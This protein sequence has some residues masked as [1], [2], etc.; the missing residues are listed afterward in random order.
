MWFKL[1]S[2]IL[3]VILIRSAFTK[4]FDNSNDSSLNELLPQQKL[5]HYVGRN[6]L[7]LAE[8]YAIKYADI[9]RAILKDKTLLS[10]HTPEVENF[11]NKLIKF[12]ENYENQKSLSQNMNIMEIFANTTEYY[13]KLPEENH[14]ME[15][16]FILKLLNKYNYKEIEKD[17][18]KDFEPFIEN[19]EK[20][21]EEYEGNWDRTLMDW[22]EKFKTLKE[23]EHKLEAFSEFMELV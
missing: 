22:Y 11:K 8:E 21:F 16:R 4:S 10:E 5:L 14:T 19:F 6:F 17:I 20:L 18:A 3:F 9:S 2:I 13:Y 12:L 15:T 23:F 7:H 1:N